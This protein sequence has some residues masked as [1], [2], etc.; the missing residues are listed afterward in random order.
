MPQVEL[1]RAFRAPGQGASLDPLAIVLRVIE[2]G[3]E[4]LPASAAPAP[5]A[6]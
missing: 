4:A 3:G 2:A 5:A 6:Q 1:K